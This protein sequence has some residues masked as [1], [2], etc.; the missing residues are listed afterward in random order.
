MKK[1]HSLQ[2][3]RSAALGLALIASLAPLGYAQDAQQAQALEPEFKPPVVANTISGSEPIQNRI[4]TWLRNHPDGLAL[5]QGTLKDGRSYFLVSGTAAIPVP[6][7]DPRWVAARNNA[8]TKA[9]MAAKGECVRYQA[10]EISSEMSSEYSAPS[11]ERTRQDA[12]RL[13]RQGLAAEGA[14]RIAQALNNKA[15]A[16]DSPMLKTAALYAEKIATNKFGDEMTKRG[17]DPSKPIDQQSVKAVLSTQSMQQ[18]IRVTARARCTGLQAL[19]AFEQTKGNERGEVAVLAI[20]TEL[21]HQLADAM[22]SNEFTLIPKGGPGVPIARQ[23]ELPTATL[24]TTVGAKLTRDENGQYVLLAFAQAA[25]RSS[26]PQDVQGAYRVARTLADAQIRQF[27]GE[28]VALAE[29]VK[30]VDESKSFGDLDGAYTNDDSAYQRI[31]A[32]ATKLPIAGIQQAHAWEARH[33][34]NNGPIVGV[35]VQWKASAAAGAAQM[36]ARNE[37]SAAIEQ[38]VPP[39]AARAQAQP[40]QGQAPA[41]GQPSGG[42]NA[43]EPARSAPQ[44]RTG[45]PYSGQGATTRDF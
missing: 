38:G 14:L 3:A 45:N 10:A 12:E 29:D 4:N 11:S 1:S 8:F 34:A 37:T 20:S 6:P 21:T 17:L 25:P 28:S 33:P 27:L 18:T 26:N 32:V 15:R 31:Q 43:A 9:M 30:Q 36:R 41:Q 13:R 5:G 16:S 7:T 23:V 2:I 19:M 24:L 22:S 44:P 42:G 35:V 40:A 39:A